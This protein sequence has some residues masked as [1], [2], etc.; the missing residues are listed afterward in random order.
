MKRID[1]HIHYYG[2]HADNLALLEAFDLKLFNIAVASGTP[3]SWRWQ[4]QRAAALADAHSGRFA[5]CTSF[6]LPDFSAD[7]AD[8]VIAGLQQ[9]IAAGA[10]ACKIWKNVGMEVLRPDGGFLLVDDP[11]FEPILAFLEKE[12]LTLLMHI[13]EPLACWRPL[14]DD[15]PHYGYY[16]KNPQWHMHGR[17]EYPSHGDLIQARDNLVRRHPGLRCIG[18]HLGSLEYDVA[19][20]ARRLDAFAN[21]AVDTSARMPDLTYQ[22]PDKVRQ[23]FTDYSDRI[24]FGTDLVQRDTTSGLEPEER[25]AQLAVTRARFETEFA[26]FDNEG[27]VE[28]RGRTVEALHLE[29]EILKKLYNHNARRWYPGL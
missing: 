27:S 29:D 10:I 3:G 23:F 19:E 7:Y 9:D 18:A 5:W 16:S 2:D 28:V 21:F 12:G 26:Y 24:L 1:A 17:D 25:Q 14:V 13:G 15:N 20:V 4:N 8:R 22:E 6:D 11:L